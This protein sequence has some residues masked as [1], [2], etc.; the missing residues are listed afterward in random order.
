MNYISI[1][2]GILVVAYGIFL[3]LKKTF[4]MSR[5]VELTVL[6]VGMYTLNINKFG[7]NKNYFI[8]F[9]VIF[10]IYYYLFNSKYI[11]Y[12][13]EKGIFLENF[14][15]I[16]TEKN[17]K[18]SKGESEYNILDIN[19]KI[20]YFYHRDSIEIDFREIKKIKLYKVLKLI[21]KEEIKVL[22]YDKIVPHSFIYILGGLFLI[23]I[24]I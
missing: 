17:I 23:F 11:I 8:I 14:E 19:K 3:F 1:G 9:L 18:Y 5:I 13:V 24:R 12:G 2:L 7:M 10:L 16:L 20:R 21:L 6:L 22:K 4:M 15:K